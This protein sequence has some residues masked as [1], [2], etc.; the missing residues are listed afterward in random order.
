MNENKNVEMEVI[1]DKTDL[2]KSAQRRVMDSYRTFSNFSELGEE[3][4][5]VRTPYDMEMLSVIPELSSMLPQCIDAMKQ[6]IEGFGYTLFRRKGVDDK[7][8]NEINNEK[9]EA[10]DFFDNVSDEYDFDTIRKKVRVDLETYGNGYVEVIRNEGGDI[11]GFEYMKSKDVVITT[12]DKEYTEYEVMQYDKKTNSY[13]PVRKR[14]RFR[15]YIQDVAGKKIYFKE[16]GDPRIIDAENGKEVTEE[17]RI[18]KEYSG[19]EIYEATEVKHFSLDNG[20]GVYG[21]PRWI[22]QLLGIL[23]NRAAE[24]VNYDYFDNKAVPPL[25]VTVSGGSLTTETK[26]GLRDYINLNIKGRNNFHRILILEAKNTGKTIAGEKD[27]TKI[28]FKELS[29]TKDGQ[30]LTY[31]EK[32]DKKVRSAFRLPPIYVGLTDDYTRATAKESRDVAEAQVFG[33]ERKLWDNFINKQ[34]F[35]ELGFRLIIFK[36]NASPSQDIFDYK[37]ILKVFSEVGLTPRE[38]RQI[39][40]KMSGFELHDYEAEN[41]EWLDIPATL[42]QKLVNAESLM[43]SINGLVKSEDTPV[44]FVEK[45]VKIREE[46]RKKISESD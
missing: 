14:K 38:I 7:N 20:S 19:K 2:E 15:R 11:A 33:P 12:R 26:K 41:P 45:L 1:G 27:Q 16:F 43:K 6:N 9:D 36:T 13:K 21:V 31:I 40:A 42:S 4:G 30:F 17:Y 37:D 28:D 32:N 46:L 23:G 22:G 24:Q 3:N 35:P 5:I 39:I 8:M 10:E 18:D 29:Q 25:A 34:V 44:E